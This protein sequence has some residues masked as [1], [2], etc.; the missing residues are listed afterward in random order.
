MF[1]SRIMR[2]K[3][4]LLKL[5]GDVYSDIKSNVQPNLILI[6]DVSIPIEEG[7][8][9]VRILPN[10]LRETYIVKDRGFF[11]GVGRVQSHY[12][13]K[14]EKENIHKEKTASSSVNNFYGNIT[15]SQI[16][17]NVR[18]SNQT[19]H[20]DESYD[21]KDELKTWLDDMLKQNLPNIPLEPSRIDTVESAIKNIE[22]ELE[23]SNSKPSIIK[24]SLSSIKTVLEGA[25]GNLLAS[26]LLYQL[27][28]FQ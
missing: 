3:V 25:A 17:Q 7:D 12:Q 16:Q 6:D 21:K 1:N 27:S 23:K 15:N 11:S 19:M 10:N 5:N 20:I 2:D 28:Q 18:N 4:D 9:L 22:I 13:V 8:T 26:G 24:E 14:V